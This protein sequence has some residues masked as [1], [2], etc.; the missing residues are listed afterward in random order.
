[1]AQKVKAAN[2]IAIRRLY[3][4]GGI[5]VKIK[6]IKRASRIIPIPKTAMI[7]PNAFAIRASNASA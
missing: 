2:P 7:T 4:V 6:P 1:M 5:T 3:M